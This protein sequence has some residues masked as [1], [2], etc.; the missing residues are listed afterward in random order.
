MPFET[1]GR[2]DKLGNAYENSWLVCQY[3]NLIR[4][5]VTS[6]MY[7]AVGDDEEGVDI[8]VTKPDNS[9]ICYQC[10]AR[11]GS[12][13][14]WRP[15]DLNARG[16]FKNAKNNWIEIQISPSSLFQLCPNCYFV[17]YAKWH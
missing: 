12:E 1:G 17:I 4:E 5:K 2:A 13:S 7:E 6:V 9:R 10:K 15:S 16:I 8:W 11:N 3:D 14:H